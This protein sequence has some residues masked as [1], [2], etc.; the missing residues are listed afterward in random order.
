MHH[1]AVPNDE[2]TL[3]SHIVSSVSGAPILGHAYED[4]CERRA[5]VAAVYKVEAPITWIEESISWVLF[6]CL[7]TKGGGSNPPCSTPFLIV[8]PSRET[9]GKV[10]P[11]LG[12]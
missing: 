12:H 5:G 1:D 11:Y 9:E 4:E 3:T 8:P 7:G 2:P 6:P 10:C